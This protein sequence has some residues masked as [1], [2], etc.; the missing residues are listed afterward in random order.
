MNG[1]RPR[2]RPKK[3]LHLDNSDAMGRKNCGTLIRVTVGD[4]YVDCSGDG[5]TA[6]TWRMDS[7]TTLLF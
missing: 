4:V 6:L 5:S 2:G 3:S 7:K 1:V